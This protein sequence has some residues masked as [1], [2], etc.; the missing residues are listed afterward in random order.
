LIA[1]NR[2]NAC[3]QTAN[4]KGSS[5]EAKTARRIE[6]AAKEDF[7]ETEEGLLYALGIVD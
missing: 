1:D 7:F 2:N 6:R 4:Q 3:V 5:K